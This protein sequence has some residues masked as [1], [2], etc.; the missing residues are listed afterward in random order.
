M[1]LLS[2]SGCAPPAPIPARFQKEADPQEGPIAGP[3]PS[4]PVTL[5]L[6]KNKSDSCFW[7][8]LRLSRCT[9]GPEPLPAACTVRDSGQ[10]H[11][12]VQSLPTPPGRQAPSVPTAWEGGSGRRAGAQAWA[13][14][15][16][17]VASDESLSFPEQRLCFSAEQETRQ[18][19][20]LGR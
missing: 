18:A 1:A 3:F 4:S 17:S 19:L 5:W 11:R 14:P 7:F 13:P 12:P 10:P 8:D 15:S 20:G 16:G 6:G 9:E 2:L